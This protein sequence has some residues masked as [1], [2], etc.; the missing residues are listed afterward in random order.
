MRVRPP[1]QA[2]PT[3]L[4]AAIALDEHASPPNY[5]ETCHLLAEELLSR[6]LAQDPYKPTQD[7]HKTLH[8]SRF[9]RQATEEKVTCYAAIRSWVLHS[10]HFPY[11]PRPPH[12][13]RRRLNGRAA[14]P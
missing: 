1:R 12:L 10:T 13:W 2:G 7:P 5:L 6:A 3:Q 9:Q 8:K 11:F 14:A 4:P